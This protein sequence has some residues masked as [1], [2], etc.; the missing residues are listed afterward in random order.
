MSNRNAVIPPPLPKA[1]PVPPVTAEAKAIAK[2]GRSFKQFQDDLQ[3]TIDANTP[4]W[5]KV[6]KSLFG[7]GK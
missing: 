1:Y 2:G 3:A 4:T 6:I 5:R 7:R